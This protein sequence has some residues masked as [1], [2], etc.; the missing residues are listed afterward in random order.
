MC[1]GKDSSITKNKALCSGIVRLR[2]EVANKFR[3]LLKTAA[4]KTVPSTKAQRRPA[5]F[6]CNVQESRL[7]NDQ[8]HSAVLRHSLLAVV[9]LT[10]LR[11]NQGPCINKFSRRASP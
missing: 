11:Y 5:S 7:L 1:N 6:A 3:Q 4:V 2:D 9:T 10:R 8:E